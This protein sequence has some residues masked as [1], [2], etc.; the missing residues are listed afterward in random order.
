M[1]CLVLALAASPDV[2]DVDPVNGPFFEIRT[3][4]AA[5]SSGDVVRVAPGTYGFF[6]IF[7]KSLRIVPRDGGM[8]VAIQ[9][10][11]RVQNVGAGGEV[12][13]QGLRIRSES[14]GDPA[15]V[16]ATCD[17]AVRFEDSEFVGTAST[18]ASIDGCSDVSFVASTLRGGCQLSFL[19]QCRG[20][21][22]LDARDSNVTLWNSTCAGGPSTLEGATG[23]SGVSATASDVFLH[24][25]RVEAG[26]GGPERFSS[27]NGCTFDSG[28]GGI[29]VV[30][31][32][33]TIRRRDAEFA[34]GE[35]G[36]ALNCAT[37]APG[38]PY[39]GSGGSTLVELDGVA[40]TLDLDA[41]WVAAGDTL[42]LLADGAPGETVLLVVG[43]ATGRIDL[44]A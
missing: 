17:G 2:L 31:D 15:L 24:G 7:D 36:F 42:G 26:A 43:P 30:A 44:P 21:S 12:F 41:A 28:D 11:V 9:G 13:V 18:G 16:V 14:A 6:G 22:G 32:Q 5:A 39:A 10:T 4:V 29:A 35:P 38:A 8:S 23:S 3:A 37:G 33:S 34:P 20:Q 1:L 27:F 19:D 40:P 25:G